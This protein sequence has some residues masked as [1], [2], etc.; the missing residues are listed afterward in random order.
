MMQNKEIEKI[1]SQNIDISYLYHVIEEDWGFSIHI[2]RKDGKAYVRLYFY[3]DDLETAYIESL[4]VH[5]E[6]RM[7]GTGLWMLSFTEDIAAKL[8]AMNVLLQ[9]KKSSWMN[10]WYQREGYSFYSE[11]DEGELIWMKKTIKNEN[12]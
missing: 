9:V 7:K 3:K 11:S 2:M 4:S 8:E 12:N 1:I 5:P 10:K 6:F